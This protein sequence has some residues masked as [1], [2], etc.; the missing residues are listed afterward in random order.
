MIVHNYIKMEEYRPIKNYESTYAVSNMGNIKNITTGLI[1]KPSFDCR[2]Y[3]HVNLYCNKK[4]KNY[5]IH[6]LVAKAFLGNNNNHPQVDHI[7]NIKTDNRVEN[8]RWVSNGENQRNRPKRNGCSSE[9]L[10]VS[11]DKKHNKYLAQ[12]TINYKTKNLGLFETEEEA[13]EAWK[14]KVIEHGLTEFYSSVFDLK[15][16]NNTI[17]M[18]EQQNEKM[19]IFYESLEVEGEN[20][21]ITVNE[22]QKEQPEPKKRGRK[23]SAKVLS[24]EEKK[25]QMK[26]YYDANKE[27]RLKYKQA[28]RGTTKAP[29]NQATLSI[30]WLPKMILGEKR[31]VANLDY[32]NY[33]RA[34]RTLTITQ[35]TEELLNIIRL[36][37]VVI[38]ET[39]SGVEEC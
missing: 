17:Q 31:K 27:H 25:E 26:G 33:D 35:P 30:E 36:S 23:P 3:L 16:S 9:F 20:I 6:R 18:E 11:F 24:E 13:H 2:G 21:T 7:N 1:L 22:V 39:V 19:P 5:R 15:T 38:N 8:L 12:I 34:K 14:S 10:G 29:N 4:Q 37:G 32:I 28:V